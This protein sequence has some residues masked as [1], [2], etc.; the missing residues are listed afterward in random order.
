MAGST[1]CAPASAWS[2]PSSPSPAVSSGALALSASDAAD[3]FPA[4]AGFAASA[5]SVFPVS[6]SVAS[7]S[8]PDSLSADS[9][10]VPAVMAGVLSPPSPGSLLPW[11]D[12]WVWNLDRYPVTAFILPVN[13]R[14]PMNIIRMPPTFTVYF[15]TL[16]WV[17]K[18]SS[19][20][21]VKSPTA[22]NGSTNPRV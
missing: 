10:S 7:V 14:R 8:A 21:V 4:S 18:N 20:L 19:R 5:V 1:S 6:A 2:A 9:G 11:T 12:D 3:V 22:R 17:L 15:T 16:P 13:I